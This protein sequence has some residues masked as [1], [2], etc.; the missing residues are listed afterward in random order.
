MFLCSL[1]AQEAY[2]SLT[3]K[4]LAF[5]SYVTR[6]YDADYVIKADDDIYLRVDRVP[7]AIQQWKDV[8]AGYIGCMKT[9]EACCGGQAMHGLRSAQHD[10][11]CVTK[12]GVRFS[13]RL[14]AAVFDQVASSSPPNTDGTSRSTPCWE[15]K[16]TSRTHGVRLCSQPES[17]NQ[18]PVVPCF[19][20][21]SIH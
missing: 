3:Q 18:I 13:T 12:N 2:L 6:H 15:A 1:R 4:T 21:H 8:Q 14:V 5:L 10:C 9:G 19:L 16:R 11:D 7:A 20:I 17:C